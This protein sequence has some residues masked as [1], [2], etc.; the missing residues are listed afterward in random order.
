MQ[1]VKSQVGYTRAFVRLALEK[2]LLATHL[3]EL[4]SNTDLVRCVFVSYRTLV[5]IL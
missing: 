4:L 2:K 1:D 3:K 5:N